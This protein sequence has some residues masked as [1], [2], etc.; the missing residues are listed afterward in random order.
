M[1]QKHNT[2]A[3]LTATLITIGALVEGANAGNHELDIISDISTEKT[4]FN[5]GDWLLGFSAAYNRIEADGDHANLL[6]ANVDFSYFFKDN[7][8]VGLGSFGIL[9][10]E[11]GEV[12][13]TGYAFGLEPNLRFY[14]QNQS[15]YT[16]YVGAHVGYA[17]G[18]IDDE[19]ESI[20][21]YGLHA[22]LL[23]PLNE[24]AYF[25]ASLKWTDYD[26]PDSTDI[27]LNTLQ[28]LVGF[29]IKF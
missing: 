12:E 3:S 26:L 18:K 5:Q 6:Y 13:D 16:P 28:L 14:F 10:P 27:D 4:P 22:G 24:N 7:W 20:R 9:I 2:V 23:F 1:K 17:Y 8:S 11:G 21:T 15:K 19:S 29:K 25:D